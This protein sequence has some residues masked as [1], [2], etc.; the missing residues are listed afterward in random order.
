MSLL[1]H[2][3]EAK[4]NKLK[5]IHGMTLLSNVSND[6]LIFNYSHRIL[7]ESEKSVLARGLQFCDNEYRLECQLK[8]MSYRYIIL[9]MFSQNKRTFSTNRNGKP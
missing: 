1:S 4:S 7:T 2:E 8:Y 5:R 9:H 3:L 6:D